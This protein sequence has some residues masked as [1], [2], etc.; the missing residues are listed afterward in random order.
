[1]K[2]LF[3]FISI[4]AIL[5]ITFISCPSNP[6]PASDSEE[7]GLKKDISY[8]TPWGDG[9]FYDS[10]THVFSTTSYDAMVGLNVKND[11]LSEYNCVQIKYSTNNYGFF[12]GLS[13]EINGTIDQVRYF[14][15][16]NLNEFVIPLDM[17][18][19][20]NLADLYLQSIWNHK[21]TS[22]KIEEIKFLNRKDPG[23]SKTYDINAKPL[24]KDNGAAVEFD[25]SLSAW[26][27]L[28]KMGVGF[29]YA[30]C[31][32]FTYGID[33]GLDFSYANGYPIET[34]ETIH[35]IKEKGFNT[36]RLQVA[37][38]YHVMDNDFTLDPA[39]MK[40][41][42]K[43]VDW[44]I[45]E[46]MY[47]IICEGCCSYY[48]PQ[49]VDSEKN[50][51]IEEHFFGAGYNLSKEDQNHSEK[52]LKA[53]W[54]Q[55]AETFNNSYDEHLVFE[56]MNEPLDL[57]D[58]RWNPEKNCATCIED[59]KILNSLNQIA[60]DTIRATGGNNEKRYLMVPT[61]GQDFFAIDLPDFK[62][63]EDS[64]TDK[65]IVSV[66]SYPMGSNT[67]SLIINYTNQLKN[68]SI[69][70]PFNTADE[71]LFKNKIPLVITE[72][73]CSRWIDLVER[74]NCAKAFMTEVTK[75]GHSCSVTMHDD[76]AFESYSYFGYMDMENNMWYD[77]GFV[78]LLIKMAAK[79]DISK[80]EKYIEDN[81]KKY[82]SIVG[83]NLLENP[84]VDMGYWTNQIGIKP[85]VLAK[86]VPETFILEIEYSVP[87]KLPEETPWTAIEVKYY[88][89]NRQAVS[90]ANSNN[91]ISGGTWYDSG[92]G[93]KNISINN[94][95][96]SSGTIKIKFDENLSEILQ[97]YG[98]ALQAGN[99][100]LNSVIITEE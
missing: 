54:K 48:Y 93:V 65:L 38:S 35:A 52:Y 96:S 18:K 64:A 63:P 78:D 22:V 50:K 43:V 58:H 40:Q 45:E 84:P 42:K 29:Q 32:N 92:N 14:C 16:S 94:T 27:F 74:M 85:E 30:I 46:D 26:D 8:F 37:G 31:G 39:F 21:N 53:F 28:P 55:I 13:H 44:A 61:L 6:A 88:D 66:H 81:Q 79:K 47:V 2:K 49:S 23:P 68:D 100:I 77:D 60:L 80:E 62:L 25:D 3:F 90:Y 56:F 41:L 1:M 86:R 51:W 83:K 98:L 17:D 59:T 34:K 7:T 82:E 69:I 71:I 72:F 10:T 4:L 70:T 20:N 73:G 24:P 91:I 76:M 33:F 11:D 75:D 97:T 36:L 9:A 87:T 99:L 67:E 19:I 5:S 95:P 12:F 57:T 15:P 89:S